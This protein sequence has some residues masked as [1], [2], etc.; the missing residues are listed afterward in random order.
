[1]RGLC[2]ADS[3][4]M[5]LPGDWLAL[6]VRGR[7]KGPPLQDVQQDTLDAVE[8]GMVERRVTSPKKGTYP[9][10]LTNCSSRKSF[11]RTRVAGMA[12]RPGA[13]AEREVLWR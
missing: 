10:T 7:P 9:E 12:I 6:E 1:M 2:F 4:R 5:F 8:A 13:G 3:D 11:G